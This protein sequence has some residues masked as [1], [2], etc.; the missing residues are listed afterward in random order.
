MCKY[1]IYSRQRVDSIIYQSNLKDEMIIQKDTEIK[2]LKSFLNTNDDQHKETIT[3]LLGILDERS[4]LNSSLLNS[5]Q[6]LLDE[7][8]D[9]KKVNANLNIMLATTQDQ[10]AKYIRPRNSK[11]HFISTKK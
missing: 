9:L 1:K 8:N 3:K 5:S 10:L 2:Q 11:G 6:M 7:I 4:D